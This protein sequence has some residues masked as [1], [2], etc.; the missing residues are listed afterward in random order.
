MEIMIGLGIVLAILAFVVVSAY[1]GLV[2]LRAQYK[3]GFA[4]IDV[5]LKRRLDLI[6]NLVKTAKTYLDHESEVL[7][8]VTEARAQ[9]NKARE[10]AKANP[11][12]ATAMANLVAADQVLGQAMSGFNLQMEAYPDLKANETI[13]QLMEELTSTENKVAYSRQGYNDLAQAFNEK[14]Q[15]FPT[16]MFAGMLGFGT[17]A[18]HLEF[19]E[20]RE[21]LEAAPEVSFD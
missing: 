17:D 12:D 19:A 15:S 6:P 2:S 20:P 13:G 14:R 18:T 10:E 9:M 8:K 7:V 4:Q 3:N 1:N 21:T 16:V 5:Q 11:G